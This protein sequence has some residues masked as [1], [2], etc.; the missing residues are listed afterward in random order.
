M[1]SGLGGGQA[2]QD[3]VYR[4]AACGAPLPRVRRIQRT[5]RL[6]QHVV[7]SVDKPLSVGA[8]DSALAPLGPV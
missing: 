2:P 4:Q 8:G 1:D 7:L 6:R 3:G 5:N